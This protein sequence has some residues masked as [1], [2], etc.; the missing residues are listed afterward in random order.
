MEKVIFLSIL[1]LKLPKMREKNVAWKNEDQI[2][3]QLIKARFLSIISNIFGTKKNSVYNGVPFS[4]TACG[5][6]FPTFFGKMNI[7]TLL[8]TT[9]SKIFSLT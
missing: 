4:K 9:M 2:R 5:S 7:E 3:N 1:A 6:T 8:Y